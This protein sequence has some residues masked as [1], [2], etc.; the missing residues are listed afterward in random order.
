MI[1]TENYTKTTPGCDGT[2]AE[3]SCATIKLRIAQ[4]SRLP[5]SAFLGTL[6][7]TGGFIFLR[8]TVSLKIL[9]HVSPRIIVSHNIM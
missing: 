4:K 2:L 5:D 6:E 8:N 9:Y 7:Q 1:P 3:W